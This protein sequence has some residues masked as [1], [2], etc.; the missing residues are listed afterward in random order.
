MYSE[1]GG[2]IHLFLLH[3]GLSI[4]WL[5]TSFCDQLV[6]EIVNIQYPQSLDV[7]FQLQGDCIWE[8]HSGKQPV[9][10]KIVV[11]WWRFANS[12]HVTYKWRQIANTLQSIGVNLHRWEQ[13]ISLQK[14]NW[15]RQLVVFWYIPIYSK[16][17]IAKCLCR[18]VVSN[19]PFLSA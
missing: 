10:K 7:H 17:N 9:P 6:S 13:R 3:L 1:A 12:C 15:P 2:V 18:F 5:V 14:R 19:H 4:W 16:S 11:Q 8:S